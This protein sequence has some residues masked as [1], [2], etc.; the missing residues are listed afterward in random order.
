MNILMIGDI[1]GDSAVEK[2]VKKLPQIKEKYHVDF[3]NINAEN[4]A[5]GRGIT[6]KIFERLT[7]NGADSLTMGNHTWDRMEIFGFVNEKKLII[8]GNY[9]K[10]VPGHGYSIFDIVKKEE[11]KIISKKIAVIN[12]LGRTSMGI[13]TEN[14]F[15]EAEKIYEKLKN[16]VDIFILDFHAEATAEKIAMGRYMDGKFQVVV[17]THTHVQT[18]DEKILPNGTGYITDLGM[19]GPTESVLGMSTKVAL[20]RFLTG[21]PEKYRLAENE[22]NIEINGCVFEINDITNKTE[23]IIRIHEEY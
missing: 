13:L 16:E 21:L 20:K 6:K 12:L 23:K 19:C 17:G 4:A 9:P 5:E 2:L 15:I 10:E 3:T 14:P 11:N 22:K 1:V 7:K 8:P 18:A